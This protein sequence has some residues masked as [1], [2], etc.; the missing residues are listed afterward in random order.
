MYE[1][2]YYITKK[3]ISFLT[4]IKKAAEAAFFNSFLKGYFFLIFSF[5]FTNCLFKASID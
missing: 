1:D 5:R 3:Y 4:G 2:F